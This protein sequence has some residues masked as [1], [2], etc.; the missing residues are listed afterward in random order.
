[1][2]KYYHL[3]TNKSERTWGFFGSEQE[4]LD[5]LRDLRSYGVAVTE[6]RITYDGQLVSQSERE[7]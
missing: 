5:Y 6:W 4:A 3:C 7:I 1:M 2:K